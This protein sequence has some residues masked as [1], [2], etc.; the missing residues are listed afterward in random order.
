MWG[1]FPYTEI[2]YI[3]TCIAEVCPWELLTSFIVSAQVS[4]HLCR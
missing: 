4:G 2:L 1:I 3:T